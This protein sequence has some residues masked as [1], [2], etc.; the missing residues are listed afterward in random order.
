[1]RIKKTVS[2]LLFISILCILPLIPAVSL[3][4]GMHQSG[5]TSQKLTPAVRRRITGVS[6]PAKAKKSLI[7]YADLRYLQVKYIDFNGQT[8]L[9]ELIVHKKIARRTLQVFYELYQMK[10]PI[11]KITLVDD[12]DGDDEASMSDNNTSAFNYRLV[13]GTSRLS[14]HGQGLA[15]DINPRINPCVSYRNGRISLVE[16]ANGRA[17][18]QRKK[19]DCKGKYAKYMIR[20]K[21]RVYRIFKKYGF[22]WGGDWNGK[23]DY[24]HFEYNR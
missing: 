11:E 8:Q 16:P 2:P 17:Y 1:M 24:Q 5:F 3:R 7:S 20:K 6:Y 15:I 9:G 22:T 18:V 12:Y 21:D 10:Y 19:S 13:R 4:A 23:K 14:K